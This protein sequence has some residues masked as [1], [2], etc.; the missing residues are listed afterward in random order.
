MKIGNILRA[1]RVSDHLMVSSTLTVASNETSRINTSP[2][3]KGLR[4]LEVKLAIRFVISDYGCQAQA[5]R[6]K[7]ILPIPQFYHFY[8]VSQL[9]QPC[10]SH[11]QQ[12]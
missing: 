8:G 4:I 5:L 3:K 7:R 10:I 6:V 1:I 12:L 9:A 11:E 2:I